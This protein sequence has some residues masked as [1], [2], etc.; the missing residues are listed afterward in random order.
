MFKKLWKPVVLGAI[1]GLAPALVNYIGVEAVNQG[2]LTDGERAP[3]SAVQVEAVASPSAVVGM[4]QEDGNLKLQYPL[5][6]VA[7]EKAQQKINTEIADYVVKMR[8]LYYNQKMHQ[9]VLDY[10]VSY[11]DADLLSIIINSGW[12]NGQSAHGYHQSQGLV[13]NKHTGEHI[14]AT[15]YV[16]LKSD[17]QLKN[18]VMSETV[19]VYSQGMELMPVKSLFGLKDIEVRN[20]NYILLG[21]GNIAMLYQPYELTAYAYGVTRVVLTKE[22]IEEINREYSH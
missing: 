18:L 15:Y 17:E 21:H 1:M 11:E 9:V 22:I 10:K 12:Y 7:D 19:K 2:A 4:A 8:D 13:F 16:H 20:D 3:H 6:Y 14:P 5:V